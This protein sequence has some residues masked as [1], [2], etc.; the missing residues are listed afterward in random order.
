[1]RSLKRAALA[2][3]CVLVMST[4]AVDARETEAD[5]KTR[6]DKLCALLVGSA[7]EHG[8]P[9]E[10]FVRLVWTESRFNPDA[11]SPKG[12]QGIAQFMPGTAAL[13][14]LKDPFDPEQALPA[15]AHFLRDLRNQFGNWGL[16]A[17]GYNAGPG[18]VSRWLAGN[19]GLPFET[20]NFVS[21][22]TGRAAEEWAAAGR[23]SDAA[24][25]EGVGA[26]EESP[27]C[28]TI[29]AALGSGTGSF[30]VA[31]PLAEWKPWGAAVAADFSRSKSITKFR[32]VAAAAGGEL[33]SRKPLL[34]PMRNRSRGRR[35]LFSARF[36]ADTRAGAETLCRA[37]RARGRGCVVLK[38]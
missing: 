6:I 12:A 14:G 4:V 33:S 23:I 18:R 26:E 17:A 31:T 1:M 29:V 34:V 20:Q 16:A 21:Q 28:P 37:V 27:D 25:E 11:V 9:L 3:F 30:R 7:S 22:I 5:E 10:F 38:N 15:S 8:L 19:S 35:T 13:R 32:R 24:A 36:T 2:A